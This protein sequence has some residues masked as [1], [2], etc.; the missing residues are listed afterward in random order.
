MDNNIFGL[1]PVIE[2]I[3]AGKEIDRVFVKNGL[4]GVLATELFHEIKKRNISMQ[5]VPVEKLDKLCNKNH[6]GVIAV[7][8]PVSYHDLEEIVEKALNSGKVPLLVILDNIT[9][10]RNFGAIARTCECAGV[11]AIIIPMSNSVRITE[12]A[13][14]TSAGALYNI[15]VCRVENIIDAILLLQQVNIE[16]IAISEKSERTIYETDLKGSVALILGSEESGISS[17]VLKRAN[18]KAKI[19]MFGKTE[20]LN[21]SVSTA[22]GVYEVIRQRLD[23]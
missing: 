6:Q 23:T 19:P 22:V 20:S 18:I 9:D 13:I 8:S 15:P 12:D 5:Y 21:V 14:K 2:A 10:V 16:I 3:K 4:N 1:R 11:D 7:I 17:S